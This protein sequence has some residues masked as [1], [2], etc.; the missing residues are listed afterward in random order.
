MLYAV[1]AVNRP[2]RTG[3]HYEIP[4]GLAGR[5]QPGHLVRVSF[6]TAEEPGIVLELTPDSPVERTKPVLELLDPL[7]VLGPVHIAVARWLSEATLAPLGACL[8]MFLPPG[9]AGHSDVQISLTEEGFQA[10]RQP[11]DHTAQENAPEE[12]AGQLLSLLVRRGPLRGGQ[13]NHAMRG[14]D[15]DRAARSL[16]AR[17]LV[18]REAVLSP[19][20]VRPHKVR[21][22]RLAIPTERIEAIAPRLG[23]ESRRDNVLEVLL[24]SPDAHPTVG[25]VCRAAGC[26]ET[27]VKGMVKAGDLI[28]S[29]RK[30]WLELTAPTEQVR[31][32]IEAGDFD[33]A[34]RQKEALMSLVEAGG[35]LPA[36]ALSN[37][38][39]AALEKSG[40]IRREEQPPT[41]ALAPR[42]RRAD[43][44]PDH[45]ALTARLIEL[46]GG[47]KALS[48]L[49][50]LAREGDAIQVNWIY[51]QTDADLN[52]L[53]DLAA[54][55]LILLGEDEAWRDPL[56]ERDFAPTVAPAFTPDQNAAWERIRAHLDALTWRETSP[57]PD[58]PHV[59][60]LHGVTGSGKTE[61]YLRAVEHALA[62]G[63]SAIILVPEIA[64]TPQTVSRVAARFP[65]QV[66]VVHSD[67]SPGERFDAWRRAR[68]GELPVIVGTRAALFT[69]LPDLGLVVLDEEHDHSF[70]QSPPFP[71]PYY[72][73]RDVAIELTRRS[74]GITILGSATP[75]IESVHAAQRGLY[76]RIVLPVRVAGHQGDL[77]Q[78]G[79]DD[80]APAL[81]YPR[82]PDQ[83]LT[84]A[85]PPVEIIDMRAEL[86]AGNISMFSRALQSALADVLQRGE[87]AILFLN[88]RGTAS[89]VFCR[90]CG[91]VVQCP[92]CDMPLTYHEPEYTLRCHHCGYRQQPVYRCPICDSRRIKHFGAGTETVQAELGRLFPEGRSIRW[93]RDTAS[94]HRE[95]DAILTRFASRD[96]DVLIGTQMIA[97]GL[98]LPGVT[99]VGVL[100]ADVGLAL[101]DFRAGERTF[102]LLTQV[103]GR[104]GRGRQ[105]GLG[106]IQTYQ[107]DHPAIQ[108]AASHDYAAFYR[109][110]ISQRRELGYPPFRR[111]ARLLIRHRSAP[112]AQ[113]EA[114]RAA[115]LIRARIHELKLDGT[116]IIG[117][118]PCFF[119]KLEGYYRWHVLVR[120]PDPAAPFQGMDLAQGWYLDMDPLDVL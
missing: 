82:H 9:I 81:Y 102:Q 113:R 91:Y 45:D 48:V 109:R 20:S 15:W 70:K 65:G 29:P 108:A 93:D 10:A 101:P 117:P 87:Q 89:Y 114:E 96:A 79:E 58:A 51:A 50:L 33:H 67:L 47:E 110:E 78:P 98:D 90:D 94:H 88:R 72:H 86:Q 119:G 73:A 28:F 118:A 106:I 62:H 43:G 22:A 100:N 13:L 1:V 24:A 71:P 111:L 2:V 64:L 53:R 95:H 31:A 6:G 23:R 66:A 116:T 49:R 40:L 59:F 77:L 85:L 37:P 92:R 36:S 56:A 5:L 55:G 32:Q 104:A 7:P 80:D 34:P 99:L 52:L 11:S 46:R 35:V 115:S 75:S 16:E 44:S 14:K 97:K 41:V 12:D 42:Y 30:R 68:A 25:S 63:R 60:L 17:G 21:V 112:H 54:D 74:H 61:V 18:R 69:P 38:A 4:P 19:P 3:F 26:T 39:R 76:Q 57:P 107:P 103:I 83:A 27:V 105:P 120:S 84:V 8:W